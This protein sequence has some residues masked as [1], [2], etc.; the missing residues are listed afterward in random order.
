MAFATGACRDI[1]YDPLILPTGVD[2]SE[3][4]LLAA[5][6]AVYSVSFNRREHDIATG[7]ADAAIGQA[8]SQEASQ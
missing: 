5:R 3:D 7:K 2:G 4:P 6:S 1:N 8:S